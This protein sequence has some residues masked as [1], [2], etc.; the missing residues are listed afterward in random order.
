M[1]DT[2]V[3]IFGLV[4]AAGIAGIWTMDILR[5]PEIDRSAG[6]LRA[7]DPS[8]G[9]LFVPHWIAE[10]G[11]A[12]ALL[13]GGIGLLLAA[14]WAPMLALVALGALVYTSTNSL[15]WAL[16][17]SERRPYAVPMLVGAVGGVLSI[18]ALLVA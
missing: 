3:A 5:S 6:L 9:T 4:M 12:A 14:D 13:V 8:N 7:R 16:A 1:P 11:T 10:Y 2:L 18:A 17:R 15:G